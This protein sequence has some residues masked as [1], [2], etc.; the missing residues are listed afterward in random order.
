MFTGSGVSQ[1]LSHVSDSN[2][3]TQT[4]QIFVCIAVFIF[5]IQP[6]NVAHLI[7]ESTVPTGPSCE[8]ARDVIP[9]DIWLKLLKMICLQFRRLNSWSWLAQ[10]CC[11]AV[12]SDQWRVCYTFK[13]SASTREDCFLQD[14]SGS[15][16]IS[17]ACSRLAGGFSSWERLRLWW[18]LVV[19][20]LAK[21]MY[22]D[23]WMW[24]RFYASR[25]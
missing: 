5:L 23:G 4:S 24:N 10:C 19:S 25:H 18:H 6:L 22:S 16:G 2:S 1:L 11:A 3:E 13:C 15:S 21:A 14:V 7:C 12:L 9:L 17:A 8:P 20:R